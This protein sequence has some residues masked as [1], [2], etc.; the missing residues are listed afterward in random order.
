MKINKE[1]KRVKVG[2]NRNE[3]KDERKSK[4]GKKNKD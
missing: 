2:E 3:E 1:K 4:Q